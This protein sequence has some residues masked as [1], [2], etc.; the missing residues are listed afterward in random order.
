[1]ALLL[2]QVLSYLSYPQFHLSYPLS[3]PLQKASV[4]C[5]KQLE[6]WG[7]EVV[8]G[9]VPSLIRLGTISFDY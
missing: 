6:K 3:Y 5:W 4:T 1:M 8:G 9:I 2:T 7:L